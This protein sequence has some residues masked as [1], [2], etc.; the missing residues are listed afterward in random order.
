M[1][2]KDITEFQLSGKT[3]LLR[4]DMNVPLRHGTIA[5]TERIDRSLPTIKYILE[6]GGKVILL[7]HLGRPEET[8]KVQE[9]FSL[10]P[11]VS[12]LEEKFQRPIYLTDNL[13][14]LEVIKG[15]FMVIENI[16]FFKGEKGNDSELAKKLGSLCDIFVLD[17]FAASHR[18][19]ASTT[20]VISFVNQACIGFLIREELEALETLEKANR[21]ILAILGGA[22]ISSKLSLINALANK[23]DHLLLGGGIA[24]TCLGSK[25]LEI[26]RSLVEPSLYSEARNLIEKDNVLLPDKVVVAPNKE[27]EPREV[28]VEILKKEEC[29]F[30]ISPLYIDSIKKTFAEA[31][32]IIWNGPMGFF[33]ED[34]FFLGTKAV[35]ELISESEAYSVIGGGD[36]IAAAAQAKVLDSINY[37]STAGGAFLNYLEG[38]PLPAL[39]ALEEKAL[40]S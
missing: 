10:K 35:A 30:D 8:G 13:D 5:S 40:E 31:N 34:K 3:V 28:S 6:E 15:Q 14:S 7:S 36:T 21:P 25:G 17:A 9:E 32:T 24:N 11:V 1:H 26:G 4:A 39:L 20:G 12:Y 29:I 22:K 38:K 27:S 18:E 37:V 19:H 2:L 16:R 23:V 33:E